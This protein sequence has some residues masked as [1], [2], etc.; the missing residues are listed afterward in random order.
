M[1]FCT[2][3]VI[4]VNRL[5][6]VI[7]AQISKRQMVSASILPTKGCAAMPPNQLQALPLEVPGRVSSQQFPISAAV[8]KLQPKPAQAGQDDAAR[9]QGQRFEA[10]IR[11]DTRNITLSVQSYEPQPCGASG[12]RSEFAKTL[13]N[14]RSGE[15]NP[16]NRGQWHEQDQNR[17]RHHRQGAAQKHAL[18]QPR[19]RREDGLESA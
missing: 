16:P 13:A 19:F 14:P 4:S 1:G 3:T 6:A 15:H 2:R 18:S 17:T 12:E 5:C 11:P 9:K 8:G 10:A 7:R